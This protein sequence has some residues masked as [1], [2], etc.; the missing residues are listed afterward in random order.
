MH[1]FNITMIMLKVCTNLIKDST[2]ENQSNWK[3]A[4]CY[5]SCPVSATMRLNYTLDIPVVK[6][7]TSFILGDK[8]MPLSNIFKQTISILRSFIADISKIN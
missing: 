1:S 2:V 5:N 4:E 6:I 3:S 7:S 8:I